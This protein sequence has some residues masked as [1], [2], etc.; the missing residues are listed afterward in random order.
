M[1]V[2]EDQRVARSRLKRH[3]QREG[4]VS[5]MNDTKWRRL[6]DALE[7][8]QGFLDFRR[9]DVREEEPDA[10]CWCGD[11]YMMF[12]GEESIE[13]LDIRGI[14]S[15]RRGALLA[16]KTEDKAE[17]L[18]EAVRSAGVAFSTGDG[19]IRVWGYVRPGTSPDWER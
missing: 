14:L 15:V 17:A 9:K 18:V 4:L 3:I 13:W 2:T 5:A 7:P 16:S 8:I 10:D 12:G 1:T 11:L 6:F 19:C